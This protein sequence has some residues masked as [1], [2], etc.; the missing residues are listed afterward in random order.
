MKH[1]DPW[2]WNYALAFF[3]IGAGT[4]A[5]ALEIFTDRTSDWAG[6]IM[7]WLGVMALTATTKKRRDVNE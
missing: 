4:L 2:F 7:I 5:I 3:M 6:L 1:T